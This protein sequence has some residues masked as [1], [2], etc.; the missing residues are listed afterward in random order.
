MGK[1]LQPRPAGREFV[2]FSAGSA[3]A[4]RGAIVGLVVPLA[5]NMFRGQYATDFTL[6]MAGSAIRVIPILIVCV[7]GQRHI[8]E[9]ITLTGIKR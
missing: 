2:S 8:I 5:L 4:I 7:K 3:A 9:G 6:L 1:D